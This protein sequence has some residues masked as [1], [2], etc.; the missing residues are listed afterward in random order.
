MSDAAQDQI[1]LLS[2]Q[3]DRLMKSLEE[4]QAAA[5]SDRNDI[6]IGIDTG[7]LNF[8]VQSA[9]TKAMASKS[10]E[11]HSRFQ[12]TID[13]LQSRLAAAEVLPPPASTT[14]IQR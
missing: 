6:E 13:D 5:R 12:R 11:D 7:V 10:S 9:L 8:A 3:R 4:T 14:I 1:R 2:E